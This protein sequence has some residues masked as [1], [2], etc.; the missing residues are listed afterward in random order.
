MTDLGLVSGRTDGEAQAV[1]ASSEVV[2]RVNNFVFA[3][4]P[5]DRLAFIYLPSAAY[6]L[7]AGMS[8]L[9]T[10]GG[11]QSVGMD[12]ND[13]GQVVGGAQNGSGN[14]RPFRWASGTM[15]DLGTLGGESTLNIHRGEAIN[16]AGNVAGRSFTAGGDSHAFM[17][18]GSMTDLGVLTGGD[19]SWAFG[20]NDSDVAVGTSN[21]TGGAFH[22]FVWDSTNGMRDLNNLVSGSWTLTR[23]TDINN[24]GQIAGWGTNPSSDVRAFLL[25]PTCSAGGGGAAAAFGAL[26][27]SG[28][29]VTD[30]TGEFDEV[31]VS[32]EGEQLAEIVILDANPGVIIDYKI[33]E[34][35]DV[36]SG[37]PG[38][39]L[40]TLDG[41][42]DGVA[43]VRMLTVK[44]S[45]SPGTFKMTVT[46]VSSMDE[47][48][49][50]NADPE[51]ME[52][53]VLD[54]TQGSPP[55]R[56]I[57]AGKNIGE[58]NPTGTLGESGFVVY[59]DETVD[60]W[61]ERDKFGNFALGTP[62]EDTSPPVDS[63]RQGRLCGIGMLPTLFMAAS[64]FLVLRRG[65]RSS[66]TC[67]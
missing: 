58:R 64:M 8:S 32:V 56:W 10:L 46:M 38:S 26:L 9:G 30:Q 24:G 65:H 34:A 45:A 41:F 43:L 48:A 63:V 39:G 53:H 66:R 6:T 54:P 57:P 4:R 5:D 44:S 11:D 19:T 18:D 67:R 1:N 47:L 21:V 60:Y 33:M 29:G 22:A 40:S 20:I 52:L 14:F 42:L 59:T 35:D 55:G 16:S 51:D 2:G 61:A 17:W 62:D 28:S 7:S 13:A 36:P 31:V 37:R 15:T 49:D 23:A 50:L 3:S 12:I 25:T 27:A